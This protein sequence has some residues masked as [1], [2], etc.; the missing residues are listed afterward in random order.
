MGFVLVMFVVGFVL[1][2]GFVLND[3][4]ELIDANVIFV[5]VMSCEG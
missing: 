2:V 5:S 3:G 1:L 4:I